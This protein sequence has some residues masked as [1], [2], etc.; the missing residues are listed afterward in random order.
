[1]KPHKL[2]HENGNYQGSDEYYTLPYGVEP[3]LKHVKAFQKEK[4]ITIWCPFSTKDSEFV[5][6]L[7]KLKGVKVLHSHISKGKDFYTYQPKKHYDLIIDNPPF[8]GTT[9]LYKRL[10]ELNKPFAMIFSLAKV[11]DKY[12][13]DLFREHNV[14]PQ[15]L[16]FDNRMVFKK[17]DTGE[18]ETKIPFTS[19]YLCRDF[20]Q[21]DDLVL[22]HIMSKSEVVKHAN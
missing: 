2:L 4:K 13:L 1:M 10:L 15:L 19:G 11:N 20:L 6:Q 17:G 8:K 3:I 22:E 12:P 5:K 16:K 18:I 9:P 7:K 14:Q 21:K